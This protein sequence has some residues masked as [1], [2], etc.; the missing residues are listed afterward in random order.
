MDVVGHQAPG[1]DLDI[2]GAAMKGEEIAVARIVRIGKESLLP[3]VAPL[4]G[5][6]GTMMRASRAMREDCR[7]RSECQLI[8]ALSPIYELTEE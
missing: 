7:K 1:P 4:G 3:P 5:R 2:C 8:T 6:P